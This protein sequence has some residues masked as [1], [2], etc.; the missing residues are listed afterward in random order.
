MSQLVKTKCQAN[1]KQSGASKGLVEQKNVVFNSFFCKLGF[2]LAGVGQFKMRVK[3]WINKL[4][5]IHIYIV[6]LVVENGYLQ[7]VCEKTFFAHELIIWG[8]IDEEASAS[9]ARMCWIRLR[10]SNLYNIFW[11]KHV[12][13]VVYP[14]WIDGAC[15]CAWQSVNRINSD[16]VSLFRNFQHPN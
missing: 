1:F 5:V 4:R 15:P 6:H 10:A 7:T 3:R 12:W 16:L 8:T 14:L 13:F 11:N 9:F 2:F